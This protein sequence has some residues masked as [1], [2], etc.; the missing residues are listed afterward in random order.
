MSSESNNTWSF[1]VRLL[2]SVAVVGRDNEPIYLHGSLSDS[3]FSS[4]TAPSS[5]STGNTNITNGMLMKHLPLHLLKNGLD[6]LEE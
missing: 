6:Y 4:P 1:P 2:S 3:I 5:P